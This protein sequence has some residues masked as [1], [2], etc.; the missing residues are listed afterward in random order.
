[1]LGNVQWQDAAKF[2]SGWWLSIFGARQ[3]IG[4]TTI[5]MTRLRS[6]F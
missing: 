1:M 5:G 6:L 4:E 3:Q 2:A